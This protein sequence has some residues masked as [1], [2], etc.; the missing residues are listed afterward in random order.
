MRSVALSP[1]ADHLLTGGQEKKARIFDL[2]RPDATPE[3]LGGD[4]NAI[5]HDGTIKSVVWTGENIGVTAGD[6]GYVK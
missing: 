6:D 1:T 3:F 2:H 4:S 5:C